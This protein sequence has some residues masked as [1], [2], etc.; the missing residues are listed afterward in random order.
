LALQLSS[1]QV[2]ALV[3]FIDADGDGEVD[4]QEVSHSARPLSKSV[5]SFERDSEVVQQHCHASDASISSSKAVPCK[6]NRNLHVCA[7]YSTA[8]LDRT[9]RHFKRKRRAGQLDGWTGAHTGSR[10]PVFPSWLIDRADFKLV[11]SRFMDKSDD[12]SWDII[13][14][15]SLRKPEAERTWEDLQHIANWLGRQPLLAALGPRR[16]LEVASVVRTD[17]Y[18]AGQVVFLQG[19]VADAFYVIHTGKVDVEVDGVR[20]ATLLQGE[21]FGELGLDN[22][23]TRSATIRASAGVPGAGPAVTTLV[24]MRI[25]D[26]KHIM[27]KFVAAGMSLKVTTLTQHSQIGR[28][29]SSSKVRAFSYCMAHQHYSGGSVVYS[30]G[31]VAHTF[32]IIISG[33]VLLQRELRFRLTNRWPEGESTNTAAD[34]YSYATPALGER[35]VKKNVLVNMR[36]LS[37]GETFGEDCALGFPTRQYTVVATS[38]SLELFVVSKENVLMYMAAA[39]LERLGQSCR[40]IYQFA[41]KDHGR[42]YFEALKA[43]QHTL[44][45][46]Y[47]VC[48]PSYQKRLAANAAA[49]VRKQ[50]QSAAQLPPLDKTSLH[51]AAGSLSGSR[52]HASLGTTISLVPTDD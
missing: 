46:K 9:I 24:R 11:F 7:L 41:Q 33:T 51:E 2:L 21:T 27:S 29:W 17:D 37:A 22:N 31:D 44:R 52:S 13:T 5:N 15:K 10:D 36:T 45:R 43:N 16:Y 50:S 19:S 14:D 23:T 39:E 28:D 38:P 48:G 25:A 26:Y 32:Y 49:A 35:R 47:E 6:L 42:Q 3:A 12:K 30:T 8:Q 40:D 34:D 18:T 4:I 20:V 1:H